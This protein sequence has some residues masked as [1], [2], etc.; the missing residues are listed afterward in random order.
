M[1]DDLM[2]V[3]KSN[4]AGV[5]ADVSITKCKNGENKPQYTMTFRNNSY[6]RFSK[7]DFIEFAVTGTRVYFRQSNERDGF[8]LGTATKDNK[9][10]RFKTS[11]VMDK[12]IGDYELLW[13]SQAKL[14]YID[15]NRKMTYEEE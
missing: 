8:K 3:T 5:R 7:N 1:T 10:K 4:S 2:W 9:S 11:L 6:L 13:D 15:I 12:F 14:N